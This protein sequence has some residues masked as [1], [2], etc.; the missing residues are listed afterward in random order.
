MVRERNAGRLFRLLAPACVAL[1]C[2]TA[3]MR[4]NLKAQNAPI[5]NAKG[6]VLIAGEDTPFKKAVL[7][8]LLEAL[9]RDG[10]AVRVIGWK[11]LDEA[12]AVDCDSVVIMSSVWAGSPGKAVRTFV[13]GGTHAGRVILLATAQDPDWECD[14]EGVDAVT[15]ASSKLDPD[16][17]AEWIMER[18]RARAA[19]PAG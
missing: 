18:L 8:K 2:A 3:C 4:S 14:M 9:E 16:K 15:G 6:R 5:V 12:A 1:L 7:A 11:D 10:Y 17:T 19:Q 13:E